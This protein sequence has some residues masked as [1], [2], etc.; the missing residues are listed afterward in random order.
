MFGG[1]VVAG[2]NIPVNYEPGIIYDGRSIIMVL[3]GLFGGGI[4]SL[5]TIFIAGVYRTFIGGIGVYAGVA[6]IISCGLVGLLF[7]RLYKNKPESISP[8]VLWLIGIVAHVAMLLSQLLLPW[9][10]ALMVIQNIWVPVILIFPLA[11]FLIGILL[12]SEEKRIAAFSL[13]EQSNRLFQTLSENSPVGIVRTDAQGKVMYVNAKMCSISGVSVNELMQENWLNVIYDEDKEAVYRDFMKA[14]QVKEGFSAEF[15]IIHATGAIV[16]VAVEAIPELLENGDINGYIASVKDI[17]DQRKYQEALIRSEN[18]FRKVLDDSPLGIRITDLDRMT[19]YINTALL[20]IL[21]GAADDFLHSHFSKVYTPESYRL[22]EIRRKKRAK[23]EEMPSEYEVSVITKK[24]EVRHLHVYRKEI[25][26]D[27][28]L[29]Y[30]SLYSDVTER[31][32]AEQALLKREEM[33]REAEQIALMGSWEYDL[34]KNKTRWS[35]N[36]Y[37]LYG[38]KPFEIEPDFDYFRSL[39]HPDDQHFIDEALVE[40]MSSR[41]PLDTQVRV[42]F[43]DGNYRWITDK[44]IP[45]FVDDQLVMLRGVNIDIHKQ[46]MA[47]EKLKLLNKSIEQTPVSIVITDASGT[48]EYVNPQFSK[49]TGYSESEVLGNNMNMLAS[50]FHSREFYRNLWNTILSGEDWEGEVQ[51]RKKNGQLY[52]E[53]LIISPVFDVSGQITNFVGVI[54]DITELKRMM[55]EITEAKEKAEE[56][57]RLKSAFLANMSHEIR[58]PLNAILGFTQMLI[59]DDDLEE[60]QKN[61][62]ISIVNR[63]SENLLQII[64]D[65]LAISQLET[66]Q[67]GIFRNRFNVQEMLSHIYS[68]CKLKLEESPEKKDIKLILDAPGKEIIINSDQV[69]I[70]QIVMNLLTNSIKFTQEGFIRFGVEQNDSSKIVFFVS[71]TG[72]GIEKSIQKN[73]FERFRQAD[74]SNTRLYGGVGLGLSIVKG[75]V[76]LLDGEIYLESE[77]GKGTT[78]RITLPVS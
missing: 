70:T 45:V 35:E 38:L 27:G 74:S 60:T 76:E 17:T 63:S 51:N 6:T 71:D 62:F 53:S 23:G 30:Q 49:V 65:I 10:R 16:L 33:L 24:G 41:Q 55:T 58:T 66:H 56:G 43:A 42:R 26:W 18:N 54:E 3:S 8:L 57:E 2:M 12:S 36:C 34:V 11:V 50:G 78:F 7:R 1:I 46:K 47:E 39:I 29:H 69:R 77:A 31:K 32:A 44:I 61:E 21:G 4:V 9:D 25:Y 48:I 75:L 15:R 13:I 68:Q 37:R 5:I 19:V 28:K 52:W 67:L 73:M 64:N 22:H 14:I 72:I 40:M 20:N 59:S